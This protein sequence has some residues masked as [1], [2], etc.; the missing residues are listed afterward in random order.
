M[1]IILF[2]ISAYYVNY[3]YSIIQYVVEGSRYGNFIDDNYVILQ[4]D[5]IVLPRQKKNVIIL[6]LES[7]ENT[8]YDEY[9][10]GELIGNLKALQESNVHF[11]GSEQITG[12]GWTVAGLTSYFF[13]VPLLLPIEGNSYDERYKGF[14][15][16]APSIIGVLDRNGYNVNLVSGAD[17]NF[18]GKKIIFSTHSSRFNVYDKPYFIEK[19]QDEGKADTCYWG[20]NDKFLYEKAKGILTASARSKEPF[21]TVIQTVDTHSRAIS[22]GDYPEKYGDDRDAFVAADHMASEFVRWLKKQ[23]FYKN[24]V[25]VVIGDHLYMAD[26]IGGIAL[27]REKRSVYN[28]FLNTG[29]SMD[30]A[31]RYRSYSSVDIAPTLLEAIGAVLPERKYGLGVSLFSDE[32]TLVEKYGTETVNL[33]LSR[34]S[35]LY[36]DFY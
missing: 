23:S 22:Y 34:R 10:S 16:N 25:V 5:E 15:P 27:P 14:L 20:F 4:N 11:R 3:K 12:T 31:H 36:G 6:V 19:G 24:T 29:K 1:P 8:F 26:D 35:R 30:E 33:E 28:V 18:G 32:P 21:F 7:M 17:S 9:L 13:G 2:F